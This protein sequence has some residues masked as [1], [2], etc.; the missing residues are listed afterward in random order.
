MRDHADT[1][2]AY[3]VVQA[4]GYSLICM[5]VLIAPVFAYAPRPRGLIGVAV[6]IVYIVLGGVLCGVLVLQLHRLLSATLGSVLGRATGLAGGGA[7]RVHFAMSPIEA[8]IVRGRHDEAATQLT[9]AMYL[10]TGET[11]AEI[12]QALGDLLSLRMGSHE[13]AARAYR[14]ARRE[15]IAAGGTRGREGA[16]YCARRLYDLYDGPLDNAAAAQA[17][18]A[19]LQ[20]SHG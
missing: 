10:H 12:A 6:A 20:E 3:S 11:G 18:R 17:E 14:K 4:I 13:L 9:T 7:T 15:W 19:R 8:L 1:E 5:P 2:R 16:T